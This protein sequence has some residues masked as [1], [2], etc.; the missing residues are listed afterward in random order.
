[1]FMPRFFVSK[2]VIDIFEIT[3]EDASHI[4]KSLRMQVN[5][6]IVL[7]CNNIDYIC[8]IVEFTGNSVLVKLISTKQCD[9]EPKIRVTLFQGIPKSDKMD[10][11]I[12]KAVEVGVSEIVPVIMNRCV[13]RP[14]K[15]SLDKKIQRWQKI[16][17]E[18]AKQSG[19]GMVPSISNAMNFNDA[20]NYAK[21]N[22][23]ILTFYEGGGIPIS[24][25]IDSNAESAAIFIGPEGGFDISE[26]DLIKQFNATICSLGN[27]ILRTE[28]AA[29][30][31]PALVIYE[32]GRNATA[33]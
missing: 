23:L 17:L 16:A 30:V 28:T 14:D 2:P 18:A 1:M 10:L 4:T 19:R 33:Q 27:R 22:N 5:E 6:T 29:I 8:K 11:I 31:A 12:Q 9:A 7:C 15:K 3:G 25:A 32:H 26:I 24:S 13:S 21:N 20:V